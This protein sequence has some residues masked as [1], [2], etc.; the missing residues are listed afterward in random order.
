MSNANPIRKARND[1]L[2]LSEFR[3]C[4]GTYPDSELADNSEYWIGGI[5]YTQ[6]K[7]FEKMWKKYARPVGSTW[8]VDETFIKASTRTHHLRQ[9]IAPK[10]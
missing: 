10:E 7:Y 3:Q 9:S 5:L 1:A 4:V 8:R 2:A 6:K